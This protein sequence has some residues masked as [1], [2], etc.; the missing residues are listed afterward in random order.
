VV[1]AL[2]KVKRYPQAARWAGSEDTVLVRFAIAANGSV[3]GVR[4]IRS[5]RF[6]PLDNEALSLPVRAAPLPP[7]PASIADGLAVVTV[8]IDFYLQGK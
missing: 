6:S 8:P 4:I 2:E 7:P 1:A 5:Q 3:S